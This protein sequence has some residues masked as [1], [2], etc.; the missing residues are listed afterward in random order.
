MTKLTSTTAAEYR[1]AGRKR[2][3]ATRTHPETANAT[4]RDRSRNAGPN[5]SAI[6]FEVPGLRVLSEANQ[7][8]HWSVRSKRFVEQ[9]VAV[10]WTFRAE[11]P[12]VRSVPLP[13]TV[14]LTR[15]GVRTMDTDNLAGGF[16]AVRDAIAGWFGWNDGDPRITWRYEQ[17]KGKEYGV[18][19]RIA[20][21]DVQ[22]GLSE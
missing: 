13:A 14:T 7:R 1:N 9:K 21:D 3:K 16:K 10:G 12:G 20:S 5:K 8:C 4:S 2:G 19:I 18:R 22:K 11:A 17:V 15:I 6:E